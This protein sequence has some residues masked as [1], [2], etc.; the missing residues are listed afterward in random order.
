[1]RSGTSAP[2]GVVAEGMDMHTALGV[3]VVAGNV[4]A[5]GRLGALGGLLEL[6]GASDFGITT[7]DGDC[8]TEEVGC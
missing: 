4:P 3:S 6:H 5:D 1:M 7:E 8:G 2:I